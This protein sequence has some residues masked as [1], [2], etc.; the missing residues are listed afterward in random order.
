MESRQRIINEGTFICKKCSTKVT[1]CNNA[2]VR[3]EYDHVDCISPEKDIFKPVDYRS[4]KRINQDEIN[5]E[6]F[7]DQ[8]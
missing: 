3:L 1:N 6:D 7:F 5:F 8:L 2:R 4:D